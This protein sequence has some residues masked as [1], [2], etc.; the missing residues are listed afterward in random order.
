LSIRRNA[1]FAALG[2]GLART[3]GHS[4]SHM[5]SRKGAGRAT[6]VEYA[7]TAILLAAAFAAA[8]ETMVP[9]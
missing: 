7:L 1:I 8:L 4:G 2:I 3:A 6:M 9:L 5:K